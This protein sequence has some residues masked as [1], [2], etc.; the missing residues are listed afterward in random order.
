MFLFCKQKTSYEMRISDL[1]SFV[2]SS[3]LDIQ[4]DRRGELLA[5]R[6]QQLG[7]GVD[8]IDGVGARLAIDGEYH[9]AFAIEPAR[10]FVILDAVDDQN[11]RASCRERVCQYV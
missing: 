6:G 7:D 2:C 3:D 5:K 1:S 11:G 4:L 8:D 9:R 10:D